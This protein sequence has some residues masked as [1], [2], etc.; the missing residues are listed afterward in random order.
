MK[1]DSLLKTD[2]E[3]GGKK[4]RSVSLLIFLKI[5]IFSWSFIFLKLRSNL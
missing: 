5:L 2:E 4:P 3:K 1:I